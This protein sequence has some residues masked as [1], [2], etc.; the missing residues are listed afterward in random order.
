MELLTNSWHARLY[1]WTYDSDICSSLCP[2]FW[3]ILIAIVLFI[4]N[5]ILSIPSLILTDIRKK[6]D[7][8]PIIRV[9]IGI[10]LWFALG[11]VIFVLFG[12]GFMIMALLG[13][14]SWSTG[15][16]SAFLLL[17]L[18]ILGIVGYLFIDE[19]LKNRTPKES[20]PNVFT[21]FIKA[22]YNNYCPK[23]TWK[24]EA[25]DKQ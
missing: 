2:Y 7:V 9:S 23:I 1:N 20:K 18:V 5:F 22:K 25:E 8:S 15:I 19:K 4:P 3:K 12:T 14:A 16:P 11:L 24:N 17:W 10:G 21:E 13:L 6:S